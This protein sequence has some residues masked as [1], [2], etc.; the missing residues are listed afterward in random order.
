M[1]CSGHKTISTTR[2][3]LSQF[4]KWR[5]NE[6][7]I[8]DIILTFLNEKNIDVYLS[9]STKIIYT[10]K[11]KHI[12][13]YKNKLRLFYFIPKITNQP[14]L[15]NQFNELSKFMND[16]IAKYP[17]YKQY[18]DSYSLP[19]SRPAKQ[20]QDYLT[21]GFIL[22][23]DYFILLKKLNVNWNEKKYLVLHFIN[24]KDIELSLIKD[25]EE[26]Q[27]SNLYN[28]YS[29]IYS[30]NSQVTTLNSINMNEEAKEQYSGLIG[31][32]IVIYK[33]TVKY[34]FK[35]N[36]INHSVMNNII[37]GK[38]DEINKK[39]RIKEYISNN[40]EDKALEY[41]ISYESYHIY[42]SNHC[43]SVSEV[44]PIIYQSDIPI[45]P[46]EDNT[47]VFNSIIRE[48]I[49]I[50]K[51]IMTELSSIVNDSQCSISIETFKEKKYSLLSRGVFNYQTKY[52]VILSKPI[53]S[54]NEVKNYIENKINP[55]LD[56]GN[57]HNEIKYLIVQPQIGQIVNFPH[58]SNTVKSSQ[59]Y[60]ILSYSK[61]LDNIYGNIISKYIAIFKDVIAIVLFRKAD[62]KNNTTKAQYHFVDID[63]V[64]IFEMGSVF[65]SFNNKNN[66]NSHIL[67][68]LDNNNQVVF[69]DFFKNTSSIYYKHLESYSKEAHLS[70]FPLIK[71]D[72]FKQIKQAYRN[73]INLYIK[74]HLNES[75]DFVV[76]NKNSYLQYYQQRVFYQPLISIK[77]NK[78]LSSSQKSYK[79]YTINLTFFN[80]G[81][82][83]ESQ[84][85][86]SVL[87]NPLN[88]LSKYF[89]TF[90]NYF[91][92]GMI[93]YL[94]CKECN[95]R[96]SGRVTNAGID[97]FKQ[98]SFYLCP[99]T[100]DVYC[101]QCEQGKINYPFNVLF[102]KCKEKKCLLHLPNN[103]LDYFRK[104]YDIIN[105]PEMKENNCDL[106]S[107][108]LIS[109]LNNSFYLLLNFTN[110]SLPFLLCKD[111]FELLKRDEH[112]WQ[113]SFKY[114]YIKRYC[115]YNYIDIDNLIC[116]KIS[117]NKKT[118]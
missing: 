26:M 21:P 111:C 63:E 57:G 25:I 41:D 82:E 74:V 89:N 8:K 35:N 116:K 99:I 110:R 92:M 31:Y 50:E 24:I 14:V 67:L 60:V 117:I 86:D 32:S 93:D 94:K 107:S 10:K 17:Q 46:I 1:G 76:T 66:Y 56:R 64:N 75:P 101:L 18:Y 70:Q 100:K 36:Q 98:M 113:Y 65:I 106:C 45:K 13:V 118:K 87:I 97:Y 71:K 16:F 104:R 102:I 2:L 49:N 78:L 114:D 58:Q 73:I 62:M 54:L 43:I 51:K 4:N 33:E 68:L 88:E 40:L 95:A 108:S 79:N 19:L 37:E 30:N 83:N 22:S 72:E 11:Y 109:Q 55:S 59:C 84:I 77:Y 48:K 53:L 15:V 34:W 27:K 112:D 5:S 96:I 81:T 42:N 3:I 80:D 6:L 38:L 85:E 44:F 7:F 61:Y 28:C 9:F 39:K 69:C 115:F 12:T 29:V 91:S 103:N 52:S 47:K 23:C 105:S 90:D 20:Q